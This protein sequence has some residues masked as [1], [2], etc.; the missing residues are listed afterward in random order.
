MRV[1]KDFKDFLLHLNKHRVNY[2]IIGGFSVVYHSRPRFTDDMDI[3]I[4]P[5]LD[6]SKKVYKAMKNFGA[7]VSN[8]ERD[9]FVTPGCFYQIGVPPVQIH[10]L[11]SAEGVDIE[12]VFKNKIK[13]L[14]GN[15]PTYYIASNDLIKNKK[16]ANRNKDKLD[17]EALKL[18]KKSK[19]NPKI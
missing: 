4:K 5:S 18:A 6:N 2:C 16:A 17:I 15:I 1:E 19:K 3:L 11:N 14:Y 9:Y 8:I 10:I 7:D 13:A 12:K